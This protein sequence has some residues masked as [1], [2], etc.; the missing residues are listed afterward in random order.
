MLSLGLMLVALEIGLRWSDSQ[1]GHITGENHGS[2]QLLTKCWLA[3]HRMKPLQNIA[4]VHPDSGEPV[5]FGTNS[6]G[7]RGK[8]VAVPKPPGVYRVVC[9]G[10]ESTL[11][12]E[13]NESETFCAQLRQHLQKRTRSRVEVINAGVPEYCPLLSYLFFK[14]ALISFQPDLIV[15]NFD[16]TDVADDYR[17]RRQIQMDATGEPLACRHPDLNSGGSRTHRRR[18]RFL[19]VTWARKKL[20]GI[21][22]DRETQQDTLEI[23]SPRG[24]Y[25]WLKDH[26]PDWSVYIRQAFAPLESLNTLSTKIGAKLVVAA[27][28]APWQVSATAS[29]SAE[30]RESAGVA[31]GA[32]Y[33]STAP[34]EKLRRFLQAH[35]IPFCDPLQAFRGVKQADRLF[36]QNAP[37]FSRHGH[38]L[39]AREL[40][41]SIDPLLPDS[42]EPYRAPERTAQRP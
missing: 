9:L 14:H 39:Y 15:L 30:V 29:N 24:R 34:N 10:D 8:E 26:P 20:G 42:S 1:T 6:V 28:P 31:Q 4:T 5:S 19:L 32:F 18:D 37:R 27:C 17:Y 22:T 40:A 38:D 7:L 23:D 16:M 2:P 21:S 25:A 11:A 41:R 33:Q 12:G 36:L 3:H 35:Q 13:V